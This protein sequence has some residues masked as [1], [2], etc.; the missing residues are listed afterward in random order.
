M[1]FPSM[2]GSFPY[3]RIREGL[4]YCFCLI[5]SR[6]EPQFSQK[7]NSNAILVAAVAKEPFKLGIALVRR[8]P[9]C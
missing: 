6:R 4:F 1:F 9:K 8:G 7:K 3:V 5:A 2:D